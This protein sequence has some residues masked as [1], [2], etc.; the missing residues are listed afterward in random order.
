MPPP[1]NLIPSPQK[2]KRWGWQLA[3]YKLDKDYTEF[4]ANQGIV[5]LC[6][7]SVFYRLQCYV[8]IIQARI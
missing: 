6:Y 8:Y 1:F 3:K 2:I 5:Y 4:E 7:P